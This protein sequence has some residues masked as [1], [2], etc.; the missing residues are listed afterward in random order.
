QLHVRGVKVDWQAV[1]AGTGAQRVDLPTYAFQREAYWIDRTTPMVTDARAIGLGSADHPLLGAAVA[2]A[3]GDGFFFSGRLSLQTHPWLADHAVAGTV[4][5]PGTAFVELAVRAGDHVGCDRLAELTLEAPLVLPEHGGV[6]V[7]LWVG[8]PE[9]SGARQLTVY[10]RPEDADDAEPWTRHADGLLSSSRG[11]VRSG[12]TTDFDPALWPPADARPVELSGF[13][14]ALAAADFGYGPTFR[15]LGAAWLRGDEIFAEVALPEEAAA[16][17]PA[18]GL[19]PA[20]LDAA[21]H[22]TALG[23]STGESQGRLPFSWSGVALHAVGAAALRVRIVPAGPE[24]VSLTAFDASGAPVCAVENLMLRPV[25]ADQL[26]NTGNR[27][28]A[29]K[30]SLFGVE[31]TAVP[32]AESADSAAERHTVVGV[33]RLGLAVAMLVAGH[34][35]DTPQDLGALAARL[36]TDGQA[37]ATVFLPLGFGG[38]AEQSAA[39]VRAAVRKALDLVQVSLGQEAFD[40]SRLV[41]VTRGAVATGGEET[42]SDLASAAVWGLLRSAQSENPGRIVLVD[43]DEDPA[44]LGLLS[45]AVESGEPQLALRAGA[46][47]APRL[48]RVPAVAEAEP[49]VLDPEGT[50]L[51]TGAT[52]TLGALFAR[53][54]VTEYGARRLLLV[55]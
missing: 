31:W 2:L 22:A 50:V 54:L 4:L 49:L 16:T 10:S 7:Q 34:A 8:R 48:A 19:H 29:P 55:S 36:D 39:D 6:Q 5:L 18:F 52:G 20:L 40:G 37:P 3:D 30:D 21:L 25:A 35:V 43:L 44:S 13:Y 51:V 41:V 14:E 42:V 11:A 38:G 26:Q 32:L 23:G 46:A 47:F 15:G 24:S 12:H 17:A 33:D 53:H 9:T 1:F 45:G 28:A 27:A